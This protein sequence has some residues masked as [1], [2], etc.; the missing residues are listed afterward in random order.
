MVS[1][2]GGVGFGAFIG[3]GIGNLGVGTGV[4]SVVGNGVTIG[5]A[6]IST[7]VGSGVAIG[8]TPGFGAD[9][10]LARITTIIKTPAKIGKK[11]LVTILFI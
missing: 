3:S 2:R 5:A 7:N 4:T 6:V 9:T 8:F 11:F 10:T 1:V